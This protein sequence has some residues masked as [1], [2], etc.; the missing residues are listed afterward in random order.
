MDK[1]K[2]DFLTLR[3]L[4]PG[5][6]SESMLELLSNG[7]DFESFRIEF[8]NIE[9]G[10]DPFTEKL[11]VSFFVRLPNEKRHRFKGQAPGPRLFF[12]FTA[13]KSPERN[14]SEFRDFVKDFAVTAGTAPFV[15]LSAG[16]HMGD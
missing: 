16:Q 14:L 8:K 13:A 1:N 11:N 3:R 2:V 10:D 4:A 6:F 12:T 7:V 15:T 9:L 5:P